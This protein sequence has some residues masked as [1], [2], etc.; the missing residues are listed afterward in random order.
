MSITTE[1]ITLKG[2]IVAKTRDA[3]LWRPAGSKRQVWIPLSTISRENR[4]FLGTDEITVTVW[5]AKKHGL[6]N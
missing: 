5:M 4:S 6:T 1:Q 3:L 2:T